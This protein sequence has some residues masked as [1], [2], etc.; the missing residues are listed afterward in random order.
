MQQ[1]GLPISLDSKMRLSNFLGDENQ[2]LL[3]FIS[4]LFGEES[5]A[6]LFVSGERSSGKTHLLQGCVFDALARNLSAVYL[7]IEQALPADFINTLSEYEWVCVDNIDQLNTAQEQELFDLYNQIKHTKTKLVVSA[8]KPPSEL[9]LLKDLKTRLSLAVSYS[10]GQLTDLEK[11]ASIK[12]KMQ[13]KNLDIDDKVYAYLF[14]YVS[15]D[16]NVVLTVI[17]QLDQA[18]LQQKNAISIPFVKKTLNI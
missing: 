16:L 17:D 2:Q 10:L 12:L 7:D 1:L 9:N 8:P 11:I 14:N 5:S 6:V 3:A 13:D 18:S 4:N 15:R